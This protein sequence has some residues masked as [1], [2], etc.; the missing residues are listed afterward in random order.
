MMNNTLKKRRKGGFLIHLSLSL[1][2]MMMMMMFAATTT[3]I[4]IT[5]SN[6][7]GVDAF[8]QVVVVAAP[9]SDSCKHNNRRILMMGHPDNYY[10]G[11]DDNHGGASWDNNNNH[12]NNGNT[13]FANR[14]DSMYG[15]EQ[16]G[17]P[18][19]QRQRQHGMYDDDYYHNGGGGHYE[20]VQGGGSRATWEHDNHY[21][22]NNQRRQQQRLSI[23]TNGRPLHANVEHWDGPNNTPM[24]MNLYSDDGDSRPWEVTSYFGGNGN[25]V[26]QVRN[27]GSMAHPLYAGVVSDH[28]HHYSSSSSSHNYNHNNYRG[29]TPSSTKIQGGSRQSFTFDHNSEQVS[30]SISSDSGMPINAK[31]EVLQGPNNVKSKADIYSEDGLNKP[32]S[33]TIPL[34]GYQQTTIEIHNTGVLE[35]P[36][37]VSFDQ[38][39]MRSI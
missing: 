1:Y 34:P 32:W 29:S 27:V 20:D 12:N 33:A 8:V 9:T 28:P 31:V 22:N 11:H 36:I 35:F 19:Q 24:S 14:I 18:K 21:N 23:G 2:M 5:T 30:V 15:F 17:T 25:G 6:V 39:P 3:T 10:Y 38:S 16:G 7:R 26:T 13:R 37:H 4:V